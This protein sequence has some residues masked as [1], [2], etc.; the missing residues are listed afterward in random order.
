MT[1]FKYLY[2]VLIIIVLTLTAVNMT[3]VGQNIN[4][5][6][7]TIND[8]LSQNTIYSIFQDK[9]GFVWIGTEDGLNRFDGYEFKVYRHLPYDKNSI[10][11]NQIN[12][13]YENKD[14]D[15]WIA[16]STGLDFFN[17][18]TENFKHI[19]LKQPAGTSSF[20]TYVCGDKY[21]KIWLG[22]YDG[23]K[24]YDPI[25]G[26][27]NSFADKIP[28][29]P[30]K[31]RRTYSIFIGS[32]NIVWAGIGS[33]I[34]RIN[35]KNDSILPPVKEINN[36]T[37]WG[38][39]TVRSIKKDSKNNVW[40]STEDSGLF[41]FSPATAKIASYN[42]SNS[43]ILSN[44]IRDLF[45]KSENEIW[46]GTRDGLSILNVSS[47]TFSNHVYDKYNAF[48]LNHNSVRC[49]MKDNAGSVWLGTFSGGISI[50]QNT[51]EK[52]N[53]IRE[54]FGSAYGLSHRVVSSITQN[55]PVDLWMGTEGGGL[56]YYNKT[57]GVFKSY[58]NGS[59][60]AKNPKNI[61][62]AL[63]VDKNNNLWVG[64]FDGLS[65]FNVQT[66][67]FKNYNLP[68]NGLSNN[69]NLVYSLLP[70]KNG[71]WVGTDGGGLSY[72]SDKG[73]HK[74]YTHTPENRKSVSSNNIRAI[75]PG[76]D[77]FLWIGTENGL[78]H[79]DKN[80]G[81]FTAFK[82]NDDN[83]AGLS[84]NSVL[85]LLI[86]SKKRLWIGTKGGGL[87]TLY[88]GDKFSIIDSRLGLSNDVI[89]GIL[90]DKYGKIWV[91]TN[92]GLSRITILNNTLP[93]S[94][95][96]LKIE[97]FTISD[98]LQ[99]NQ[100]SPAAWKTSDGQLFFGGIAGVSYFMPGSIKVNN[101]KPK[102]VITDIMVRN[103]SVSFKN[104]KSPLNRPIE[105]TTNITLRYDE[106][107]I[108][109][110]FAAL[111]FISSEKNQYAYKLSGLQ[112]DDEW[113]YV[114]NQR[115]ATYTNLAAGN[116]TFRVKAAN[117]DGIWSEKET[118]INIKVL[119]P[120]WKTWWA[121]TL[122]ALAICF[123]LYL[124]YYY[125]VKTARLK[126]ELELE[127]LTRE[128]ELE[129]TQRKMSFFTNISHEIK[130]PLTLILAPIDKLL[131][132][133]EGNNKIQNQLMLMQRNGDRLKRLINQLLDFRK[134][135]TG[136]MKLQAAEGNIVRF[137]K[138]VTMAFES[139]AQ[140]RRINLKIN[141]ESGSIRAWF[142]RDK[143]EKIMYNI[144]S[145]ALKFTPEEGSVIIRVRTEGTGSP[146][147]VVVIEVE[148]NGP[149][150]SPLHIPKIF[151]QFNH[152]DES[153][154]NYS[155]TGIGLSFSKGLMELHHGNISVESVPAGNNDH[156]YTCFTL[157]FPLGRDHLTDEEII[158]NYKDS[159]NITGYN[160][161]DIPHTTRVR[162]EEKKQHVLS[163]ADKEKL[164]ML[165]VEDNVEVRDFVASHFE[166]D[167]EIHTANNGLLGWEKALETIPDI[168]ISDVMMPEM[169]GTSLCSKLKSDARTS[170]IPVILLTARTPLIFK[171]EGLETGADDYIT[172]PFN[173]NILEARIW[174]LLESRQLLRERYRKDI[175]LQ[176]TNV[177]I[178]SPDEK[179]LAKV[180]SFIERNI[181]ESSLSVEELGKEVGMS[182]V[183]L[184]RKIKAL[185][186]QTAVEFIRSVRLK[187]AAQ[188]LEQNKLHVSEVAYMVGFIDI[189]YF[190]R[191]FKDQFGH[192]PKEYASFS[193]EKP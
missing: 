168:I 102:V 40:I 146:K 24:K 180:M 56:N 85:S 5:S 83:A 95:A 136:S 69:N 187:R 142:D 30:G 137:V 112:S 101:Y 86:D 54:Q 126:S 184:Y 121:Y 165:V 109:L 174:N 19:D 144:L 74:S 148:D 182:R 104:P 20:I 65:Y 133:N 50:V 143:F 114:G 51:S 32:D 61:V 25:S 3:A 192:T 94:K 28:G 150:I 84:S 188:I 147:P 48:S 92:K 18:K 68:Q 175:T 149:G 29:Y 135:E 81:A 173:L 177:A 63:A 27:V 158:H 11:S 128:K 73:D 4:F 139:Y 159:E 6:R 96:N 67:S 87:N 76:N 156:G 117:N 129:L 115:N 120:I 141:V 52:F 172:K 161:S 90:E 107:F 151:D 169:S 131:G 72:V 22:T 45:V 138:E 57:T 53:S 14:G 7:L 160:E 13:I 132:M 124:F 17:R 113:H 91:S 98:G 108:T 111:N 186:N 106:A 77:N 99:S 152:F 36:T 26:K 78:N 46:L 167:F 127:Y 43:N 176:P 34:I 123:L 110:K 134:F 60:S 8:G 12:N 23:L 190:R 33:A 181:A 118:T 39:S 75:I 166:Q 58:L 191:C 1:S 119:P 89:H 66:N 10:R 162:S 38:V 130:T 183:T 37:G 163:A 82:V 122:Y 71:V 105:Q 21:G 15:L 70:D 9:T 44:T 31:T 171:I 16:T 170:H 55:S 64:T 116:Y 62:K 2:K 125:S 41:Y 59:A 97:N 93:F 193:S 79:F 179:F 155:G 88:N 164:I 185:T 153:G 145:N 103:S 140:H 178:T 49:F 80:K 35:A 47:G 154:T 100:F 189:D 157:K 42:T